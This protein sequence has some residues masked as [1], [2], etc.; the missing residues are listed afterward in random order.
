MSK[1]ASRIER[2]EQALTATLVNLLVRHYKIHHSQVFDAGLSDNP[3]LWRTIC[4]KCHQQSI[5]KFHVSLTV[6]AVDMVYATTIEDNLLFRKF[7]ILAGQCSACQS[8]YFCK[9][10]MKGVL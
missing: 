1:P 5:D 10:Q 9:Y 4:A 3:G 8:V 2:V 6:Y 7:A